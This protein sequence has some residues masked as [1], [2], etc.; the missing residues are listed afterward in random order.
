MIYVFSAV[1]LAG[2]AL[3]VGVW[4]TARK[5]GV[6]EAEKAGVA[7]ERERVAALEK[8]NTAA[9]AKR[10]ERDARDAEEVLTDPGTDDAVEW[11]RNSFN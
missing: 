10:K 8:Q 5:S 6:A 1:I 11:L 3:L 9:D 7:A 4:Y 2:I